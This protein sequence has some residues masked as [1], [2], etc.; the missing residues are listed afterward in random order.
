MIRSDWRNRGHPAFWA[1][2]VHRVSGV[3]LAIFLPLHFPGAEQA[4]AGEGALD[5]FLAWTQQPLLKASEIGLVFFLAAHLTGGLRLLVIE[6]VGWHGEAQKSHARRGRRYRRVL[7]VA[8]RA[9]S[10]LRSPM[11]IDPSA[12]ETI[13][14]ELYIRALKILPD[15]VKAGFATLAQRET[16]AKA[17][18]VLA[19]MIRNIAVAEA[20]DN[21][22]CQDTGIP[23]YNVTIGLPRGDRWSG[24][25]NRDSSRLRAGDA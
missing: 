25:E 13:A 20:T 18:G 23:I 14:K 9:Q 17:Q 11:R 5:A 15:D 16:V 19:T 3:M 4:L 24:C 7:R 21:L 12:V 10:C 6:F 1:F 8:L 2:L 22:L